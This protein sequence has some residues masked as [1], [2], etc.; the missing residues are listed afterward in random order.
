MA[1]FEA[2]TSNTA[3]S[4]ADQ[5]MGEA[6]ESQATG[7]AMGS[8]SGHFSYDEGTL[9]EIAKEWYS[10]HDDILTHIQDVQPLTSMVGPGKDAEASGHYA[11]TGNSSGSS[12]VNAL[13]AQA[14]YAHAQGEA[15]RKAFAQYSS[16]EENAE[17]SFRKF[18]GLP[19]AS[20]S[21]GKLGGG[22]G[23]HAGASH[24]EGKLG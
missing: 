15:C 5:Q 23:A 2:N 13:R 7:L 12:F 17:D 6:V 8:A 4:V 22:T 19:A 3:A 16:D 9:K 14:D 10:L 21:G 1:S 11:K 24:S 18:L 20:D